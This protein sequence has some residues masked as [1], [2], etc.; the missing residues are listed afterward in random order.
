MEK[1]TLT[2]S[3]GMVGQGLNDTPSWKLTAT[4]I[5]EDAITVTDT[6]DEPGLKEIEDLTVAVLVPSSPS[7]WG[8]NIIPSTA[9][10][11]Y[12][13]PHAYGLN[14]AYSPRGRPIVYEALE[15]DIGFGDDVVATV[16][17][18]PKFWQQK[19]AEPDNWRGAFFPSYSHKILFSKMVALQTSSLPRWKPNATI[20]IR[21]F[22]SEDE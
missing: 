7:A 18:W 10:K 19:D 13:F 14:P 12:L 11:K 9:S 22:E 17:P 15:E 5:I 6:S 20:E 4:I 8:S 1:K 3:L 2:E 21:A 16:S